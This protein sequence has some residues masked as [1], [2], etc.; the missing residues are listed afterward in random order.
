MR[1]KPK[2]LLILDEKKNPYYPARITDLSTYNLNVNDDNYG[3]KS[4]LEPMSYNINVKDHMKDIQQAQRV[5]MSKRNE[6]EN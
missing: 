4:V 1:L 2:I 6:E 3:I 5:N